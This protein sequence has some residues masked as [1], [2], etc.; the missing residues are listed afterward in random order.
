MPSEK[1]IF[2]FLN[3]KFKSIGEEEWLE[4][5]LTLS[6]NTPACLTDSLTSSSLKFLF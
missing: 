4:E 3:I 1:K 2:I 6:V 5:T